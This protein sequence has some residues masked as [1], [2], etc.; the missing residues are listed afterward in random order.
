M[1][2]PTYTPS[3]AS[4]LRALTIQHA[5]MLFHTQGVSYMK[6]S[7]TSLQKTKTAFKFTSVIVGFCTLQLITAANVFQRWNTYI[8]CFV[9]RKALQC[10]PDF[11]ECMISQPPP[12]ERWDNRQAPS[13]LAVIGL[14]FTKILLGMYHQLLFTQETTKA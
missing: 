8:D 13:I 1:S 11:L 14:I 7:H 4:P 5:C 3:Q 6:T 12:L 10:N 9:L 2:T